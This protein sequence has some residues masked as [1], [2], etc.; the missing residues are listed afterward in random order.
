MT[1]LPCHMLEL[2]RLFTSSEDLEGEDYSCET[3]GNDHLQRAHKQIMIAE[4]PEVSHTHYLAG[5]CD[6]FP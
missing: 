5:A 2:L 4:Q 6:N 1:M 3:C